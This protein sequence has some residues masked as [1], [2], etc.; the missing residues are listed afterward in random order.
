MTKTEVGICPICKTDNISIDANGNLVAHNLPGMAIVSCDYEGLPQPSQLPL[1]ELSSF[2]F[3]KTLR[4]GL[5]W[6]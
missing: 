3:S 4:G 6:S 2:G 5:E 1:P